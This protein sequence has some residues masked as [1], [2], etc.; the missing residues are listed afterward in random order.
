[1]SKKNIE[2]YIPKAIKA[3]E[4]IFEEEIKNGSI[5]NEYKGYISSFGASLIQSGLKPT[6]ALFEKDKEDYLKAQKDS[7][8]EEKS[9]KYKIILIILETKNISADSLLR[10]VIEEEEKNHKSER[11]LKEDI[12]DLSIAIKLAIRTFKFKDKKD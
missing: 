10:Y 7:L 12:K 9:F 5:P 3:I 2:N 11:G 6:L 8:K 1:M 4:K